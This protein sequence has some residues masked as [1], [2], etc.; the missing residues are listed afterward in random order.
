MEKEFTFLGKEMEKVSIYYGAFLIFWGFLVSVLSQSSSITSFIPAFFGLPILIFGF[1]TLKF[2]AKKKVF[3]H[4]AVLFGI[5]AFL[6]GLDIMRNI[7][8]LFDNHWADLSKLMLL[9][10]GFSYT[11][12]CIK[13]F[14]FARKNK[15]R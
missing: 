15:I 2:P 6:G 13:S 4:I 9:I 10:T 5:L 7:G 3:M 12:L 14:I 11:Y 8:S 1:L